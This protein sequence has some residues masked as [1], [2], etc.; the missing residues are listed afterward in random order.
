[1]LEVGG[2]FFA[3]TMANNFLGHGFYQFS[4]ELF[5]R[6]FSPENGF[7][8]RRIV[9]FESQIGRPR[10]YEP[11]DPKTIGERVELINGRPTYLLVHAERIADRPIFATP[12][13]Q[14][15]YSALWSKKAAPR[16]GAA[17]G[18]RSLVH[19]WAKSQNEL[20]LRYLPGFAYDFLLSALVRGM[21]RRGFRRRQYVEMRR[22]EG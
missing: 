7:R 3:H 12:P 19:R 18:V 13:Q 1:M 15:D 16:Y 14:A 11:A 9:A 8:V 17:G 20:L 22:L 10:W 5:Y 21:P 2:H 6:V 4:P